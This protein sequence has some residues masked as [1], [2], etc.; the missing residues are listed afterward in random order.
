MKLQEVTEVSLGDYNFYL[1]PFPAFRAANIF[2]DIASLLVPVLGAV[3]PV[4]NS[5]QDGAIEE[6]DLQKAIPAIAT[7]FQ[8]M[9]GDQVEKVL[10][11]LLIDNQNVSIEGE[12]TEDKTRLLTMDYANEVF[13]TDIW[14][15]FRLVWE[16]IKLNY[17]G[18]FFG[19]NGVI[20]S[21]NLEESM[22]MIRSASGARSTSKGSRNSK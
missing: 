17:A 4:M 9:S 8:G 3:L 14:G 22:K 10:K 12:I 7:A 13:A 15:M 2:G 5:V 18:T 11:K 6:E 19:K 21:G 1:R 20:Q 16:V